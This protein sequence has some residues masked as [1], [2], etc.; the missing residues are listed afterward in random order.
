MIP[1]ILSSDAMG[2]DLPAVQP[3]DHV[4]VVQLTSGVGKQIT[5]PADAKLVMFSATAPFWAR[6]GTAA[7]L[8]TGDIT[9]GS[10]PELN[11]CVR[12]VTPG[13]A[14][15]LVAASACYVSLSFYR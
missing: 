15:G 14:I 12:T 1:I 3:S 8:P 13:T 11:P 9:N 7:S 2:R 10:G 4:N 5:T 6:F